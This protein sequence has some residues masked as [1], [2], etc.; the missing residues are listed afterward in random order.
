[1]LEGVARG[2]E[3]RVNELTDL[4]APDNLGRHRDLV[5]PDQGFGAIFQLDGVVVDM[6]PLKGA[7]WGAVAAEFGLPFPTAEQVAQ[8]MGQEPPL[9]V[10][11]CFDWT[12]SPNSPAPK[13]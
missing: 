13:L 3:L 12:P 8:S 1:M 4:F 2:Q 10:S 5:D 6:D 11:R 7:L 9:V